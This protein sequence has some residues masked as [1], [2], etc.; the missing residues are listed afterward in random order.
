MEVYLQLKHSCCKYFVVQQLLVALS[1]Y[2]VEEHFISVAWQPVRA[3]SQPNACSP[4]G[5]AAPAAAGG[6][7]GGGAAAGGAAAAAEEEKKEEEP[8]ESDDVRVFGNCVV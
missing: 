2:L 4:S 3:C 1:R 8:E 6:A 7:A 5:G